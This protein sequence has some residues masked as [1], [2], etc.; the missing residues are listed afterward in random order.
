MSMTLHR[1]VRP[2]LGWA[3]LLTLFLVPSARAQVLGD[4]VDVRAVVEDLATVRTGK[5]LSVGVSG[6]VPFSEVTGVAVEIGAST[7]DLDVS[8][9]FLDGP[10]A[11]VWVDLYVV[12]SATGGTAVAGW[13]RDEPFD[14]TRFEIRAHAPAE[15]RLEIREVGFF[16][17]R[18]GE[19]AAAHTDQQPLAGAKTGS[20]VPPP[21]VTRAQW[22]ARPFIGTPSALARPSYDF[23]TWHHAAGYSAENLDQGKAQMRA[24]QD[25]HQNVRGWS[26][27]GYQFAI[28]RA[29][30]LYQGRPFMDNSTSLSQVPVLALGAH[31][32]GANTGNIGVVIMGCYH[33][34][35]GS[36]CEQEITPAAFATYINLF[37][38]L[39]ERYGV[40]PEM[41]RGHRDFGQTACPGDN[42]YALIPELISRVSQVLITGNEP[43]GEAV[44]SGS[45]DGE[46]VVS[47]QWSI[48]ADFGI[49][50]LVVERVA[51]SGTVILPVD[52]LV[53]SS[54]TDASL[55][56]EPNV[57]YLLIASHSDGRRQE[58]ARVELDIADP[59]RFLMT[60]AFPNPAA[61]AFEV[62]YFLS[63][64]G[65]VTLTLHDARG[66][67]VSRYEPGFVEGDQWVS[68]RYDVS[69]MAAGVYY[70]RLRIRSFGGTAFDR[71]IPVVVAR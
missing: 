8:L 22:N 50:E 24:M 10:D 66:R 52:A 11:G 57:T 9:R 64:E 13:R 21:L 27:I 36:H 35:E 32:G 41:I 62:R 70:L 3:F 67:E 7:M 55:A 58:M 68:R 48:A 29:G 54:Y 18:G 6:L 44:M 25:L 56:G 12:P 69:S 43:L 51:P 61:D 26:D 47:L 40:E 65:F 15:A 16:D 71:T 49:E 30:N 23:M 28:D 1:F 17:A 46:G 2:V 19:E 63:A 34:P 59:S 53:A 14:A 39:S 31:A 20:I 33:P 45:V 5:Q 4:I 37:A 42:N 60:S 38:F